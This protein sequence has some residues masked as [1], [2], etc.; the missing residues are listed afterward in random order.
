MTM[1]S[2]VHFTDSLHRPPRE[3]LHAETPDEATDQ[4]HSCT[5]LRKKAK[6]HG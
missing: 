5:G 2:A 4:P 1:R 6:T 3:Y